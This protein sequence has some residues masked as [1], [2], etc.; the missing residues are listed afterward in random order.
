[1]LFELTEK[2][3]LEAGPSPHF[4]PKHICLKVSFKAWGWAASQ[5][6]ERKGTA[7]QPKNKTLHS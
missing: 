5:L 2:L 3:D 7:K 1:M 4:R 6:C